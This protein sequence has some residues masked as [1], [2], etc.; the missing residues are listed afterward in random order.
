VLWNASNPNVNFKYTVD[1]ISF[2]LVSNYRPNATGSFTW[3]MKW[4]FECGSNKTNFSQIDQVFTL[5]NNNADMSVKKDSAFG[6]VK[7]DDTG[8]PW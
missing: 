6:T 4:R 7:Y 5:I 8:L 3:T 1:D 2:D